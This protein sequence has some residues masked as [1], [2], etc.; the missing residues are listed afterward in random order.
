MAL[1]FFTITLLLDLLSSEFM[2]SMS[3]AGSLKLLFGAS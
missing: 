2:E 3:Y 1:P